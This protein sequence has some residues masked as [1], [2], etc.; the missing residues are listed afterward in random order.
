MKR[1]HWIST[2]SLLAALAVTGVMGCDK[3]ET[4]KQ[5]PTTAATTADTP[6]PKV[7]T[8]APAAAGKLAESKGTYKVDPVHSAVVFSTKHAGFS[9][10]YGSFNRL[11][12]KLVVDEDPSKSSIELEIDANS[13]FTADKKRDEHLRSPDF[14]NTKQFP[15]ITFKSSS[16]KAA[17][18]G[19]FE[20]TGELTMHGVTK[21]LTLTMDHVGQ[22]EFPM[23]KSYRVGFEGS[24]TLKRTDFDMKNM[25]AAAG[26][27][28]R[29]TISI[30]GIRE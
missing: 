5:E 15:T 6:A 26:D 13:V 2:G 21:P 27:E 7:E 10:T 24:T 1:I 3:K 17:G 23:D 12:G 16:I 22:G 4:P 25:L 9:W 8:P 19:K 18:E 30:E 20:V 28:V 29:F 14:F 11:S